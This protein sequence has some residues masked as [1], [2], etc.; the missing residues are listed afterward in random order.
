[1]LAPKHIHGP[2]MVISKSDPRIILGSCK[3]YI[4]D[5]KEQAYKLR[6]DI[7]EA[8][9]IQ[10]TVGKEAIFT[11]YMFD[12]Q[13]FESPTRGNSISLKGECF[14]RVELPW[15]VISYNQQYRLAS[16]ILRTCMPNQF[17]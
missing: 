3:W 15:V 2:E 11:N 9:R 4:D 10:G 16:R 5:L 7:R 12:C 14:G 8:M 6:E 1:M 17:Y 13:G